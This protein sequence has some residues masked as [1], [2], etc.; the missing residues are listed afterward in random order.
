[1]KKLFFTLTLS[2]FATFIF[3]QTDIVWGIGTGSSNQLKKFN[4]VNANTG[5]TFTSPTSY[6]TDA[7]S[8]A[9]GLSQDGGY[10]YYI[11]YG[12][13]AGGEGNGVFDIR[14]IKNDGNSDSRKINNFDMNGSF[15]NNGLGFVRLGIDRQNVGWIIAGESSTN[16][17][18]IY[19]A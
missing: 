1:M 19:L 15:N 8:A 5:L 6:S 4:N 18:T 12:D 14:S 13:N 16:T 11:P 7:G 9:L 10:L 2:F 3:A 17:L